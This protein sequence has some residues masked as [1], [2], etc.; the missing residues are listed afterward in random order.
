MENALDFKGHMCHT[1]IGI[2]NKNKAHMENA[3]DFKGHMCHT[4]IGIQNKNKPLIQTTRLILNLE[5]VFYFLAYVV[6][7]ASLS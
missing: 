7:N 3:L 1:T 4:T 5:V 2:Q 6:S